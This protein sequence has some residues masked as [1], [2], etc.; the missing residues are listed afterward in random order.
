[1]AQ[2]FQRETFF[3]H[4]IGA[5][6]GR[7]MTIQCPINANSLYFNY[8]GRHSIVLLGVCDANYCFIYA[9]VGAQGRISDGGVFNAT[10]FATKLAGDDLNLPPAEPLAPGRPPVPYVIVG[11]AAFGLKK[12]LMIPHAGNHDCG[13]HERIFNYRLSAARSRIEN[14]FGLLT[15]VFRIFRKPMQLEPKK[16]SLVVNC[17]VVLHNFLRQSRSSR[18]EYSPYGTFDHYEEVDGQLTLKRG[19][20]RLE[21]EPVDSSI[22]LALIGRRSCNDA[23]AIRVEFGSFYKSELGRVPWQDYLQ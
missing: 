18:N 6:D 17:S 3:H 2:R 12:N 22:R 8:K 5:I 16:A 15:T 19:S 20:W 14:T 1:M 10:S 7:H 9:N 13:T 23:K 11:D 21:A 4:C